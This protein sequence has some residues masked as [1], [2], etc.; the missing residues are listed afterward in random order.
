MNRTDII[1]CALLTCAFVLLGAGASPA[2]Q[3]KQQNPPQHA[4][5]SKNDDRPTQPAAAVL[6]P[7]AKCL[8]C[9]QQPPNTEPH[10]TLGRTADEWTALFTGVLTVATILL[11]IETKKA[12][13]GAKRAAEALPAIERAYLFLDADR[14]GALNERL[15]SEGGISS[16]LLEV[17]FKNYGRTPAIFEGISKACVY[18]A[19]GYPAP[20]NAQDATIPA[21][22]VV[23]QGGGMG[24]FPCVVSVTSG[25]ITQAETGNG[26]IFLIGE[27]SYFDVQRRRRITRFCWRYNFLVDAFGISDS[28]ALNS[29]T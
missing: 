13:D 24:P 17:S 19:T 16:S 11:W 27:V 28:P 5:A 18:S 21:G 15:G 26:A 3:N 4:A 8:Q 2:V 12:S 1:R 20:R 6:K 23:A 10:R 22:L 29:Y 7:E 14:M 9:Q 25:E